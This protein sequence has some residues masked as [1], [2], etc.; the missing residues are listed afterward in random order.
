MICF[1]SNYLKECRC[2][3]MNFEFC[4]NL[5]FNGVFNV[6]TNFIQRTFSHTYLRFNFA[7]KNTNKSEYQFTP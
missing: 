3:D 7:L 6:S 4:K 5:E 1:C 2:F